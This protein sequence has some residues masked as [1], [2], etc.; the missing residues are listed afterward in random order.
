MPNCDSSS[1]SSC[2]KPNLVVKKLKVLRDA[3]IQRNLC[4]KGTTTTNNLVVKNDTS[5]GNTV[6]RDNLTVKGTTDVQDINVH[7]DA[8]IDGNVIIKGL[9]IGGLFLPTK[10]VNENIVGGP[11]YTIQKNDFA[12]FVSD[13]PVDIILP[14]P[15]NPQNG[16]IVYVKNITNDSCIHISGN[17]ADGS[18]Y[19][20][21]PGETT[22]FISLGNSW[23]ILGKE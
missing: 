14:P 22:L 21:K 8:N 4:V 3:L 20:E 12:V 16:Q 15:F 18:P 9:L 7:G 23:Q 19:I 5:L 2:K 17:I 6:V 11:T 1:S 13:P 10:I